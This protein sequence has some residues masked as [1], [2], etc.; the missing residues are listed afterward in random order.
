MPE[1]TGSTGRERRRGPVGGG[2]GRGGCW[3]LEEGPSAGM[4]AGITAHANTCA[5]ENARGA[6]ATLLVPASSTRCAAPGQRYGSERRRPRAR[7][8]TFGS[9]E[10]LTWPCSEATGSMLSCF[11]TASPVLVR[12]SRLAL[13]S[14]SVL[15]TSG[16]T[17]SSDVA[18]ILCLPVDDLAG[19][20]GGV[21]PP[22][23]PLPGIGH[24][25]PPL[26]LLPP[27]SRRLP[28]APPPPRLAESTQ[29]AVSAVP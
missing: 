2:T 3:G 25:M 24:P 23:A 1:D 15:F 11:T 6:F 9:L 22:P 8:C 10:R 27:A 18:S 12:K 16:C 20:G 5:H 26:L 4:A 13:K 21:P 17:C 19:D 29:P 7:S 28:L 14:V